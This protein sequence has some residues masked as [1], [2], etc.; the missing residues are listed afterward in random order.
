ML[1]TGFAMDE[2]KS[3]MWFDETDGTQTDELHGLSSFEGSVIIPFSQYAKLSKA[4]YDN[5]H[6]YFQSHGTSTGHGATYTDSECQ[7]D[8]TSIIVTE[9][10]VV[11][12]D[13]IDITPVNTKATDE[14]IQKSLPD[15]SSGQVESMN[16]K[17][18]KESPETGASSSAIV[19][20][21]PAANIPYG[22]ERSFNCYVD[23]KRLS[24]DDIR[25]SCY[26]LEQ[27][28]KIPFKTYM[29]KK[30]ITEKNQSTTSNAK[31]KHPILTAHL[32]DCS[33]SVATKEQTYKTGSLSPSGSS[34]H[35]LKHSA[36]HDRK[37]DQGAKKPKGDGQKMFQVLASTFDS[38][39]KGHPTDGSVEGQDDLEMPSL[40]EKMLK[41]KRL[42]DQLSVL[43]P[44][45][46]LNNYK[47]YLI[48]RSTCT[49]ELH[50]IIYLAQQT[51]CFSID[52]ESNLYNKQPA[53]IQIELIDEQL[54]TVILVEMCHLPSAKQ[55][56]QFWLIRSIFKFLFQKT[57]TIYSWGYASEELQ[58]FIRFG[59]FDNSDI[60]KCTK[61]NVQN[62]FKEWHRIVYGYYDTNNNN[63]WGLQLAIANT[64][65]QFLDKSQTLNNWSRGLGQCH[66]AKISSMIQY[67]CND[68]LSVTKLACTIGKLKFRG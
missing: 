8:P 39:A 45:T 2:L 51:T 47:I 22:N 15:K 30:A 33:R 65:H 21:P 19:S 24:N 14:N 62:D 52:T 68:C 1:F 67:A 20:K 49:D 23:L 37:H 58:K 56:L 29:E 11:N 46:S 59:L 53:L 17:S 66:N 61:V 60:D 3:K 7:T 36:P 16:D 43:P 48:N 13:L 9:T 55:S 12:D 34:K 10:T 64:Y 63:L 4:Y 38:L 5:A 57:K 6:R 28:P 54:S 32:T 35:P 26:P 50:H 31:V 44:F 27:L 18:A 25:S 40:K 42:N 41:L